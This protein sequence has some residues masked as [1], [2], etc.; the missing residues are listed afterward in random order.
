MK[1]YRLKPG[2]ESFEVVDGPYANKKFKK[3]QV[4]TDIPPHELKRFE[5]V[6]PPKPAAKKAKQ[7]M[8][9]RSGVIGDDQAP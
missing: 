5:E 2:Q 8:G 1:Q 3:G 6:K 9:D 4:Y 7:V